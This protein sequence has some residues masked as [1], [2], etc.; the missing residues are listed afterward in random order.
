MLSMI[1]N[2]YENGYCL[3][4]ATTPD[5]DTVNESGAWTV[6]G[7]VQTKNVETVKLVL[8]NG[9]NRYILEGKYYSPEGNLYTDDSL[10]QEIRRELFAIL[11]EKSNTIKT[12]SILI[13][14]RFSSCY[15]KNI[16]GWRCCYHPFGTT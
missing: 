12:I 13:D 6:D 16:K 15:D 10:Y 1:R 4:A 14:F 8:N 11:Q 3:M 2:E 7:V 5:N 9:M